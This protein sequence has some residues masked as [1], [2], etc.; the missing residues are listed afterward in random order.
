MTRRQTRIA[1]QWLVADDRIGDG[2]WS[3][4]RKLPRGSGI[5]VIYRG[6]A[7]RDRAKLLAKLRQEAN[8]RNLAIIDERFGQA[9]R[10]HN[11]RELRRAGLCRVSLLL[12]SPIFPTS[13]HPGWKPLSRMRAATLIRLSKVPVIALGGMDEPRFRRIEALGFHGWAGIDA[14]RT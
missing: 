4:I 7:K 12:L 9:A 2:L 13:S 5:I 10:V 14:F 3:A 8:R 6:L 1:R 11:V